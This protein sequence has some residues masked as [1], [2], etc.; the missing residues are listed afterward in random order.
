MTACVFTCSRR[1][2]KGENAM[3]KTIRFEKPRAGNPCIPPPQCYGGA[4]RFR[5]IL[6]LAI[7]VAG[8]FVSASPKQEIDLTRSVIVLPENAKV[9]EKAAADDIAFYFKK[10][11]GRDY[12]IVAERDEPAVGPKVYVGATKAAARK[13]ILPTGIL[14]QCFRAKTDGDDL[15]LV[16]ASQT[17]TD[18]AA[19]WVLGRFFECYSLDYDHVSAPPRTALKLAA[20]DRDFTPSVARRTIYTHIRPEWL[21]PE[22]RLVR[23]DL[24]RRNFRDVEPEDRT[25]PGSRSTKR[26]GSVH[27]L[28]NYVPPEIYGKSHPEYFSAGKNGVHAPGK[29]IAGQLCFSNPELRKLLKKRLVEVVKLDMEGPK[30]LWP[31]VYRFSQRDYCHD[32]LCW[33]KNC[34]KLAERLGGQNGIV[35]E[36]ANELAAELEKYLPNAIIRTSAY[37]CTERPGAVKPARNVQIDYADYYDK[38]VDILPLENPVNSAQL[39]LLR[40]WTDSGSNIAFW[41]YLIPHYSLPQMRGLGQPGTAIDAIIADTDLYRR[42]GIN[43]VFIEAE[44]RGYLQRSFAFLQYFVESQLLFD[45]DQDAERLVDIYMKNVYGV[46]YPEMN[47]YLTHLRRMQ[48]E[49]PI[50]RVSD[51]MYRR[52]AHLDAPNFYEKSFRFLSAAAKKAEGNPVLRAKV[53]SEYADVLH[54]YWKLGAKTVAAREQAKLD[55]EREERIHLNALPW[56][57]SIIDRYEANELEAELKQPKGQSIW[58]DTVNIRGAVPPGRGVH[59]SDAWVELQK[60][61]TCAEVEAESPDNDLHATAAFDRNT[62]KIGVVIT[63]HSDDPA[64]NKAYSVVVMNRTGPLKGSTAR[65]LVNGKFAGEFKL[66][67]DEKKGYV[68]AWMEPGSEI[69]IEKAD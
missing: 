44:H 17:A 39:A 30:E 25:F 36:M 11:T 12:R 48:K 52:F 62:G 59:G 9:R 21:L 29:G 54:A 13:G 57:K 66:V 2:Y 34:E 35:V 40:E 4:G 28:Y 6:L 51:W 56:P 1:I 45:R 37:E 18:F 68:Y 3:D 65:K 55:F 38:S 14:A 32:R 10:M 67:P 49:Y 26:L 31:N 63:R 15:Y 47:A 43:D 61:G 58:V 69:Y 42:L 33:C 53:A 20:F 50:T 22:K 5:E 7:C 23:N 19:S 8:F 64:V 24:L 27:N 16:G 60:L 41:K 46:A